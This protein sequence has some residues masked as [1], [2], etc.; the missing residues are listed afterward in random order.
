MMSDEQLK[1]V[2]VKKNLAERPSK[3]VYYLTICYVVA[4][5]SFDPSSKCGCIIVSKDNR[6]LS[7]GYNGPLKNSIDEEIPLVRPDRYYHFLHAEENALLAYNGSYQDI[8][9]S[10]AYIT[11]RPCSK[12]LR[13]L[14]QKGIKD[15]RYGVNVTKVVDDNDVKAQSIMLKH[16]PEVVLTQIKDC[17]GF[18]GLLHKTEDYINLK[19]SIKGE[20]NG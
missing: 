1:L 10:T 6:I 12:C 15:I 9:E 7:A 3:D 5:K 8:M 16:H 14:I 11:G 2:D 17:D 19:M 18:I 20:K 4:Q 13:M